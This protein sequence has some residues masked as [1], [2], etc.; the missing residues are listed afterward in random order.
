M[1]T[2][3]ESII[4]RLPTPP[5]LDKLPADVKA[6]IVAIHRQKGLTWHQR[7]EKVREYVATLPEDVKR[8]LP[9]P[10]APYV[11]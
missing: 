1:D 2:V 5:F 3:P 8:L 11:F 6:K 4:M 9:P 10:P 7:H